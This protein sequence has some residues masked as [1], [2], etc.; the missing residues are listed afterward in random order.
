MGVTSDDCIAWPDRFAVFRIELRPTDEAFLWFRVV[1]DFLPV[2]FWEFWVLWRLRL[3]PE[4]L[5]ASYSCS[6]CELG[7]VSR[8]SRAFI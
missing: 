6:W 7:S 3:L 2:V 4:G 8:L 1:C 5:S